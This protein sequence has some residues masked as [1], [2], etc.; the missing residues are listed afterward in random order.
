MEI[1][2]KLKL[3]GEAAKYDVCA[4]TAAN[5]NKVK[6]AAVGQ[7]MPSG[8]CHSF[9]PDGR[10]ISLFKV[11]L[12]NYC[13]RDCA[14]CPNQAARDVPRARFAPDELARLFMEFYRRNY[15][16]GLFLSSG[17]WHSPGQTM[18]E[19]IK[20]A[21][22]LREAYKFGGYIHLK[23]LPG[24]ED[25]EIAAAL[26]LAN[27]VSLNMEAPTG[28]H[29]AKLSKRKNFAGELLGGMAKISAHLAKHSGTTHT[30]Q[31]II[32]AAGESDRDIILSANKLYKSYQLKRAYFSAFQPVE[33]TPLSTIPATP[34]LR[35]NRLYQTDFLLR[36]YGF[37][38]NDLVFESEGNLDLNIDPKLAF[39]L[40]NAQLFPLEI[41][42]ASYQDLLKVPGIGPRTARKIIY[43]RRHHAL[44]DF[45]ELK[46]IGIVLKRALSFV[47]LNGKF[48][49]NRALLTKPSRPLYQQLS[50]WGDDRDI[51]LTNSF[52]NN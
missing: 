17:L 8:I 2:N 37:T 25:S 35:E 5:I 18:N 13:E 26:K 40:N 30:T 46:N 47:T 33:N 19:I 48:F 7:T 20:V 4:S 36:T 51:M 23:I 12:T 31:Y 22:I 11:L 1:L 52:F 43:I 21:E 49:G 27:R 15:V 39:A 41:N 16:E 50:L 32:G 6:N 14:Y 44:K 34:L 42:K 10:C 9:T 24:A 3:L 29:L 45:F 28:K 38:V